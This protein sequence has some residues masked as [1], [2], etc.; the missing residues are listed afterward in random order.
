V[1]VGLS[2]PQYGFSLPGD[3]P[4]TF[5]ACASWAARAESLGF[6]SAWVSD[7]LFYSFARYGVA[8][9]PI[10]A[11]EALTTLAGLAARTERMRLGTLV[12]CAAFRH[13]GTLAKAAAT[14]D[15][16]SG[17]RLDLGVGAGWLQ[18]E[19]DAFGYEFGTV[20]ERFAMLEQTLRVL[21]GSSRGGAVASDGPAGSLQAAPIS[22]APARGPIPVWVGG[23]GGPRLLSLAARFA[24]GWNVVWR[25]APL[26][27]AAKVRDVETA[28][29]RVGRDPATF[30]RSVGLYCLIGEDDAS[31]HAAFERA[32]AAMPGD[33]MRGETYETWR[34]DTLSGT[35]E[36]ILERI[37]AFAELGVEEVVVAPWVLPFAV[38]EPEQVEIFAERVLAPLRGERG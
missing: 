7:H 12:L 2:L 28:C 22:P 17:G 33:A 11:L 4:I 23:K 25:M 8:H 10:A 31:T 37:G 5:E 14:I 16:L 26:A 24:A 13:P 36:H 38:R 21:D 15:R 1:R 27:Y 30:R 32:R 18:D 29:E 20:G 6:D 19:F 34:A 9:E 3:E 35:P